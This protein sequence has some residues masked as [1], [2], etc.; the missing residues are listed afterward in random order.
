[1]I[2]ALILAVGGGALMF[3]VKP[4]FVFGPILLIFLVAVIVKYPISGLYLYMLV[5]YLRPQDL[6]GF[7]VILRP[8]IAL[9]ALTVISLAIH[10][11]LENRDRITL[12]P[13]DKAFLA[14]LMAAVL[15]NVTSV[16]FSSS[17]ETTGELAKVGV[18]YFTAILLLDTV[19]RLRRYFDWYIYSVAFVSLVQIWTYLTVGL[20]RTTG[21]G[22]YGIIIGG[23]TVLGGA[24]PMSKATADVNGVGGYSSYFYA[25]ASELGLGLCIAYPISYYLFRATANKW[26]R[27]VFLG[28]TG[29]FIWSIVVTGS[30]GAFVGFVAT[31]V[32]ILYKEKKLI[33]GLIVAAFLAAPATYLVSDEYVNRIKSIGEYKEDVSV[34]I[35]FQ[36]WRAALSMIADHPLFGVGTGNFAT[37]YGSFYK[38]AGDLSSYT[39]PHNIFVQ[40]FAELGLLGI[41]VYLAFIAAIFYLNRKTRQMLRAIDDARNLVLYT[42]GIDV[43]LL[44]YIV[45]GQFITATYYPHLFQFSVWASAIYLMARNMVNEKKAQLDAVNSP[46]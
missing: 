20:N 39:S 35:R 33:V 40:V 5:T 36:V 2:A 1:M 8:N 17:M 23:A 24:G 46:A 21:K 31:L 37:A 25:N 16:W 3:F 43:A 26:L 19:P 38:A 6:F 4:Y 10:R 27:L 13:N 9:L 14:F 32:Y 18:F 12:L 34:E 41:V 45:A 42:H 15:S 11:R 29:L 28:L 44:G 7:L 22:G 30:R